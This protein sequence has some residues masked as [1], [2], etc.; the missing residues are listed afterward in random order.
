MGLERYGQG[1]WS[2]ERRERQRWGTL[3]GERQAVI[4][5]SAAGF[6]QR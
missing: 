5:G 2:V 6:W 4:E 1:L 3:G